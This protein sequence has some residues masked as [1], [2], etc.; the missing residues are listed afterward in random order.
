MTLPSNGV[1][2]GKVTQSSQTKETKEDKLSPT[3]RKDGENITDYA[4]RVAEEH[5]AQRI[6]KEEEAKVDTNPTEAQKAAGNYRKGHIKVDGLDITIEQ[7]K[8]SIRRGTDANGKQWESEMHNTYGYIRG[9]E[10]ADGDH[11]D[12]FLSDN[13]TEGKVFVVDQ[14]NKDGSFD[15]HKVMYSFNSME[16]AAQAYRDQYED[17]WKVGTVTEV[18][19]EEFKKWVDSSVRKTKPSAEYKSVKS[20]MGVGFE[21]EHT[22]SGENYAHN[23]EEIMHEQ[24]NAQLQQEQIADEIPQRISEVYT[25]ENAKTQK[26]GNQ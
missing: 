24:K 23:S 7:P 25:T 11:I 21:T 16:E 14:V 26:G 22:Q 6:R 12:I 1:P 18:S 4:E 13:P 10:S 9:T 2:A 5:Q 20:E 17:G 15:E 8:G 3:P 19:R